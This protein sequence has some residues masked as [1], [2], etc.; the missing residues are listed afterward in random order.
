MPQNINLNVTPYNDDFN[1]LKGYQRV[2]FKPGTPIQARELTTLQTILQDQIEKFGKHFFKEGSVVIPGQLSYDP[3]YYCVQIDEFHLGIPVSAYL[4]NMIGKLIKGERSGITAKIENYI[5]NKTSERNNYT[6]Y[7][8]YQ[9]SSE[10]DFQT[11]T[12]IDGENLISVEDVNY[13]LGTIRAN[14]TFATSII[15]NSTAVGSAAKIEEGVYFIRGFFVTVA[16]QSVILDQYTNSPS[17]RVG[18]LISEELI[19]ASGQ[20]PD[21]F[22][23]AQGF[24]NYAAPGA[25]RLKI[26]ATLIKKELTD[27][28]DENFIEL[29]R[30]EDGALS[31]FFDTSN[32]NL[33]RDEFARRTYDESG[34]YYVTPF[35]VRMRESLNNRVGNN[36]VYFP[37]QKTSQGNQPSDNL[38][39]FTIS[40]GKAY[41]RGY[42]V[43][44]INTV[45]ADYEKPRDIQTFKDISVPF[46]L[47]RQILLNN[48]RGS[49]SI[50]LSSS[51]IVRLYSD[52]SNVGF[53]T[54]SGSEIGIAR[55]YDLKLRN[56]EYVDASTQFECS[57]YDVQTYTSVQ[58][59]ANIT[60]L[61][62]SSYIQGKS[63][64]AVGYLVSALSNSRVLTLYQVS[65]TFIVDEQILCNEIDFNRTI[66]SVTDYDLFDVHSIFS[67]AS[68]GIGTFNADPVLEAQI[69]IAIPGTEFTIT[70]GG[71]VTTSDQNFYNNIKVG[72]IVSY[73]KIGER[74]QT[75]NKVTSVN[76]SARSIGIS[77]VPSVSGICSGHL[78]TSTLTVS[79]FRLVSLAIRN[80]T[81]GFLYSGLPHSNISNL[82]L[83]N[84]SIK[85]KKS[86]TITIGAS[87]SFSG[88]LETD[89]KLVLV[90]FDE[91][92]YVLTHNSTG[93]VESLNDQKLTVSG[94]TLSLQNLSVPSGEATLTVTYTKTKTTVRKKV[95]NRNNT[96]VIDKSSL[97]SSGIGQT[98]LNDGLQ[99]SSV[100]GTRVQDSEIS[101]NI[102]DVE[103]VIGIFE[104][105]SI[106]SPTLPSLTLTN[107]NTNLTNSIKGER[108]VG[109]RSNSVATLVSVSGATTVEIVYLNENKFLP[110]E[111]ILF[112][113]SGITAQVELVYVGDRDIKES[114]IFD[115]GQ[116]DEYLDFSRIVRNKDSEKPTKKLKIVYNN[117]TID[118]SDSGDFVG[119]NSYDKDRYS[120]N[121]PSIG[122][123]RTS[124]IIDV[125]PRVEPYTGTRSPFDFASR[126]FS[127]NSSSSR[128]N[129]SKDEDIILSYD[130]YLPRIDKLFLSKEGVFTVKKGTSSL[131]PKSPDDLES[132]LEVATIYSPAYLRD[133]RDVKIIL[134]SHKRYTM[135]DISRID[136][137]LSNV[138]YYTSLSLLESDTQNLVIRDSQTQLDRFKCGFFVDNFKSILGGDISNPS[139]KCSVDTSLGRLKP[140]PYTS[141]I[142][143]LLGSEAV[144][145][146]GTTSNPD[147]DLRFVKDLG[148]PNIKKVGDIICLNYS[149]LVY[150]KNSFA[151]RIENVNPFNTVNWIGVIELS[152]S[153]DTW[154]E[155]RNVDTP[156]IIDIEGNYANTIASLSVDTNTGLSPVDWGA[157]ET[158]WTGQD[159]SNGPVLAQIHLGT[160]V[161][162]GAWRT[163]TR[164]VTRRVRGR[165]VTTRVPTGATVRDVTTNTTNLNF[166]NQTTTTSTNQSR[167]GVQFRVSERFDERRLGPKVVSTT[168]V[169]VMR[170]RNIEV[171]AKRLKPNTRVYPFFDNIDMGRY[172]IPKLI[173]VT[174]ESGT[175]VAGETVRGTLDPNS[176]SFRLAT[177]N[178]KYGPYNAPTEVY[179][180]NPYVP[181]NGLSN[182]YSSSTSVLNVDT[183]SL[184]VQ[185]SSQF[186]GSIVVGMRLVGQSSGAIC[187]VSNIRLI[188]DSSGTLIG[189]LFIPDSTSPSTPTFETGTK[190]L[191]LTTSEL[192]NPVNGSRGSVA[193][194]NFTSAGILNTMD[195]QTLRIRNATIERNIQ[196]DQRTV[197][198]VNT[199]LVAQR[200]T[201]SRTNIEQMRWHD[202]LAQSFE[203]TEVPG[204]FVTKCDVF[205]K[206]KDTNNL[207]VTLQIRTMR[208]GLPTQ[209]ILPFSEVI[210]Q[211]EAVRLSDDASVPT[212]FEFPSPVY[213]EGGN[214]YSI[215]L[216]SAS[217]SY[218]VWISRMGE[219]DIS[220]VN[221]PDSEKIIVS[222]QP[223]LG[224]LF[225]SQNGATWD[226]SQLE[227]LK[228]SLYRAEFTTSPGSVRFYNPSLDIGNRQIASLRSN[229]L[230][231]SSRTILIGLSTALNQTQQGFL[232]PGNTISQVG[233]FN[234]TGNLVD[235]LGA[236]G[237]G[238]T[239]AITNSGIGFTSSSKVY[240]NVNLRT[241][242]G[243]GSGAKVNLSISGGVAVAATVTVGGFGYSDGDLLTV[244][245]SETDGIGKNL[246]ISVP[247]VS[248][249]ITTYN[250]ILVSDVQG[251][252]IID[253]VNSV[254]S[255]I[256]TIN[257]V[258]VNTVTEINDGLHIKVNHN[259]HGMYGLNNSVRLYGIESDIVPS[260]VSAFYSSTT[261]ANLS[262]DS[263]SQFTTFENVGVGTTTPGY[264]IIGDEIV[265]YTGVSGNQ[266][267]GIMRGVDNTRTSSY[268]VGNLVFKY[269]FNGISLRRI[270]KIHKFTDVNSEKY[271][272]EIDSYHIKIDRSSSGINREL[273]N[274]YS[275]PELF[276]KETKSGGSYLYNYPQVAALRGGK[277]TQNIPFDII[278]P[279]VQMLLPESTFVDAKIRTFSGSSVDGSEISFVDQGFEDISLNSNNFMSST[280]IIASN[281]NEDARLVDFPG[282][283]SFTMELALQTSNKFVS[284]MIDLDRV[285]VI[286][287]FNRINKPISDFRFDRRVNEL[288]GDP[289]AAIYISKPVLIEKSADSLK[290]LFDAYRHSSNE[291][292]VLYRIFRNDSN[293]SNQLFELF[294][295]YDNLDE[296]GN[297]ISESNKSG[298]PD[299]FI[300]ASE[301]ED[302]FKS[303]E[304]NT[305]NLPAFNGFQIKIVMTGT[306]QAYVPE[307]RDFRA[308]ASI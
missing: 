140:Q 23:N 261:N 290:V 91:E 137:R 92:D 224:S 180:I 59:N 149:E 204:V 110:S 255:G 253:Q 37:T 130:V 3:E 14:T 277:A 211:P 88:T 226:A 85:I 193:E 156:S 77:S 151:T 68:S 7:I 251:S 235:T 177:Q 228:F 39:C 234:F 157:W 165:L 51:N 135:K 198:D 94:R 52:R 266:L 73:T 36:G 26:E 238:S 283:K 124:D 231:C 189:S 63:S 191:T 155:T 41:V 48:V 8:K 267:T 120:F 99:Y 299:K 131:T 297:V 111:V 6:I 247:N 298:N 240:S 192:N 207:P 67:A 16:K 196:S 208:T 220:T 182:L 197:T 185:A 84:S 195:D 42:E 256:N 248:G 148:S 128:H 281:I 147:A 168:P 176:I 270:N 184:E 126:V 56:S 218:N 303:Y 280:R 262:L 289:N 268:D 142:D 169:A 167:Q 222:Q 27:F 101:L 115:N 20:Y 221:R 264:A 243:N 136:D 75:Y 282:R 272:I 252:P 95:Y 98:T 86:Y 71:S 291:I 70:S 106:S 145:G 260:T 25:D 28:N 306:N 43:E 87:L 206:T 242:S 54:S 57:L 9:S 78:P 108:I 295:G 119:V 65:G 159:V 205:F 293:F 74:V 164:E 170:S 209:E 187:R 31:R 113:E 171:I 29:M 105:S 217:D 178:H 172:F 229:S 139:Y 179:R 123:T 186:F 250:S 64:G 265:S 296:N 278:R 116:R 199:E 223:L 273:N 225:K 269:E 271:P 21:L 175:F 279:N 122:G 83:T 244:N 81:D 215:V 121:I 202:P 239:L 292:K 129:L 38:A 55:L 34:D 227:D 4:D 90:P 237:I 12:F 112:E 174:M 163:E 173:E 258:Y 160:T 194:A 15:S 10:V 138:E 162:T 104:S 152:P 245:A 233:N 200:V 146:I 17:Y 144:I 11:N 132:A 13:S 275:L 134:K 80:T 214:A 257:S 19:V 201:T 161:T 40:P 254:I 22:D 301:N 143:L 166:V 216:L 213:L 100:Y 5:S 46:S 286:T 285:N 190:T 288:S 307:I 53:G 276:L 103:S 183:A 82:D 44:T 50:S 32:Y 181:D 230:T 79:D 24:S 305:K 287:I 153:S 246:L 219:E 97:N 45:F 72:D 203:V 141:S 93:L 236:I 263:A 61:P 232:V 210:I 89:E 294:P 47:G 76:A 49:K 35:S 107:L 1:P 30:I 125:R 150:V 308:I 96:I 62:A 212:T 102:S 154:V 58:V 118:P 18:L 284:P 114:F 188:T 259:N 69:P 117:Y 133:V 249:I 60:S 302:D 2:L 66:T 300:I 274:Q 241:I 33:I 304:F 127:S 109:E 158:T